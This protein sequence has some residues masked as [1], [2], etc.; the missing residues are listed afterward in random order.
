MYDETNFHLGVD[1]SLTQSVW[2]ISEEKFK[3][4]N[5]WSG[6][7]VSECLKSWCLISEVGHIKSLPD[8]VI[9]FIWKAMNLC[10]FEDLS[11]TPV[12]VSSFILGMMRSLPYETVVVKIRSILLKILTIPLHGV[13]LMVL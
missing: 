8:I 6:E 13:S 11:L 5:L 4:K 7:S 12:H 1:C 2:L 9:W 10:C 3:F